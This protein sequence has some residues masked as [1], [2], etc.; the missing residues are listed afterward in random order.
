[1]NADPAFS[2]AEAWPLTLAAR[3]A[4]ICAAEGGKPLVCRFHAPGSLPDE[5]AAQWSVLADVASEPNSF[6]ERWF[7]EA[8]LTHLAEQDDIHIAVV[9]TDAGLLAGLMP[10]TV[11]PFYGRIPLANVQNWRHSNAFLATPIVLKGLETAFWTAL[12]DALGHA[13]WAHGLFHIDG[14][15]EDGPVL[16][17]LCAAARAADRPCDIVKRERRALL[18]AGDTPDA[19]W[20]GAVR[21]K[22]RK[23]LNRLANRLG[24]LGSVS[25]ETLT[26]D[27]DIDAWIDD[28][29]ALERRGWKGKAGSALA[30]SPKKTDFVRAA[31]TAAHRAERLQIRRIALDDKPIAMLINFLALPGSF[32][33]KIAFDEDY[34]RFSPGVLIERDN[35]GL[36]D[37]KDFTWMDSC[38]AEDHP[39]IDSL[40]RDRRN[41]VWVSVPLGGVRNAAVFAACRGAERAAATLRAA[42]GRDKADD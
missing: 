15:D 12:L 25:H 20:E 1:M 36:L 9:T 6:G 8:S 5:I 34:A 16:A 30:C 39:M 38:A 3:T 22:K 33:F 28:F 21:K 37:R 18:R 40:W 7:L 13:G 42:I 10:L 17:G 29:L 35:L 41:I 2:R 11:K 23:E 31:L 24:E 14:L 19:Y 32:S 27:G 26:P 4:E